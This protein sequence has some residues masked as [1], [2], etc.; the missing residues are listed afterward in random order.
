M[1]IY[2]AKATIISEMSDGT[3]R[4]QVAEYDETG[5]LLSQTDETAGAPS[6]ESEAL[7]D[8]PAEEL[9][10]KLPDD[11]PGHSALMDAGIHT[12]AQLRKVDDL[13]S[14]PGVG[15]ITAGKITDALK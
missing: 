7:P 9:K 1:A 3:V 2:L 4:A 6:A 5:K 14:I 10:G 13:T 11:F 15:E 12:Y 8:K